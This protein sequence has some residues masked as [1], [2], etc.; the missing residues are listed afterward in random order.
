[1]TAIAF[2]G[3][4]LFAMGC[5]RLFEGTPRADVRLAAAARRLARGH[6]LYCAHEYT[7]ANARFAAHAEPDNRGD[8]GAAGRKSRRCATRARS[9]FRPPSP[10]NARPIP[11]FGPVTW[12]SSRAEGG[13]RQLPFMNAKSPDWRRNE[14]RR[15]S[16][17]SISSCL[18][19]RRRSASCTTAPARPDARSAESQRA[20]CSSLLA[21]K[22]AGPPV[23]ACRAT[24]ERHDRDRRAHRRLPRRQQPVYRQPHRRA[25]QRARRR[26]LCAGHP[27]FG[28]SDLCRGDIAQVVDPTSGMTVG[29]CVFGDR[30]LRAR[31]SAPPRRAS[32]AYLLRQGYACKARRAARRRRCR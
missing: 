24:A 3:D 31:S 19:R 25:L 23:S 16:M 4:T 32:I 21:G 29:S 13:E 11:S 12:Q 7:L 27:Q 26:P 20:L 5:G 10:R 2:V 1:M 30:S 18:A 17:R 14:M 22:V 28:R 8:R 9:R 6:A 15:S